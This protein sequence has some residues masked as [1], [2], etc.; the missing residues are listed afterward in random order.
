MVHKT[1]SQN[2]GTS[3]SQQPVDDDIPA[4][5]QS[6]NELQAQVAALM[7]AVAALTTRNTTPAF[8]N[9]RNAQASNRGD[10]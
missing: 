3:G 10:S 8:R 5:Q 9:Q 2:Y 4:S 7:D 1:H 6:V